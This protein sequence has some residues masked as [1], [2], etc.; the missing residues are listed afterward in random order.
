M[1][2][3][4]HGHDLGHGDSHVLQRAAVRGLA[5]GRS[6]ARAG[7]LIRRCRGPGVWQRFNRDPHDHYT[8]LL[9]DLATNDLQAA[10][11][12]A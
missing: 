3:Y 7:A 8:A 11:I 1:L 2:D 4:F 9:L 12:P 10:I 6:K 5:P